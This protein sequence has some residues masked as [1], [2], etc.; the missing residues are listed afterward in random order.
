MS[1]QTRTSDEESIVSLLESIQRAH[2]SKDAAAVAEA[3]APGKV[4][5]GLAPPLANRGL[6]RAD[7]ESWLATWDGGVRMSTADVAITVDG[8]LGVARRLT[9]MEG[10]NKAQAADVDLWFR[11]TIILEKSAGR[12]RITH[13]HDSVPFYMDGSL[14][15]AVNLKPEPA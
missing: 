8:A 14:G 13:E 3:F 7:L 2:L 1:T 6:D 9:R 15:A 12:W 5:Y 4:L 10:R 11:T